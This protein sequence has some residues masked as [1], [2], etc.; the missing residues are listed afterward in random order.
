MQKLDT[1]VKIAEAARI[2][3]ICPNTLRAWADDG[4]IA[5]MINPANGYRLFR[6]EDLEAF[7]KKASKPVTGKQRRTPK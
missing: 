7:L 3:G 1:Y 6:R 2:L 5:A 4:K